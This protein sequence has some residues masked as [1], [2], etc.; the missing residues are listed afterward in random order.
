MSFT[1]VLFCSKNKTLVHS[2][3]EDGIRNTFADIQTCTC[4]CEYMCMQTGHYF[5]ENFIGLLYLF[6]FVLIF[7]H[8]SYIYL[9]KNLK[10]FLNYNL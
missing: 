2:E 3:D 6:I 9:I 1:F 4:V 5:I 8:C 7:F 10:Y